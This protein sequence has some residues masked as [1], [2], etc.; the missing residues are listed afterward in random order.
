MARFGWRGSGAFRRVPSWSRTSRITRAG[1]ATP[2]F[3]NVP[4]A[5]AMS[6]GVTLEVPSAWVRSSSRRV[7]RTPR[8][9]AIPVKSAAPTSRPTWAKTVLIDALIAWCSVQRPPQPPPRTVQPPIVVDA[10]A[11]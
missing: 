8:R 1:Q 2:P 11:G 7:L 10:G 6:S 9:V 4:N 5:E 3:A